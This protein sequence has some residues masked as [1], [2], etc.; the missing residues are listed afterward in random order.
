[1]A[2]REHSGTLTLR[3]FEENGILSNCVLKME[4]CYKY[5]ATHTHHTCADLESFSKGGGFQQLFEF[6]GGEG[7]GVWGIFWVIL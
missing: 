3:W 2:K 1:M 7:G 6:A 5:I 4:E